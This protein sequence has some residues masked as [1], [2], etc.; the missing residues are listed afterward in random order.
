MQENYQKIN[1]MESENVEHENFQ[2]I[3]MFKKSCY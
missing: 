3:N 1:E 2:R